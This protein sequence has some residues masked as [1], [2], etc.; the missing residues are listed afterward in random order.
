MRLIYLLA[1][2]TLCF[3]LCL[4]LEKARR[5]PNFLVVTGESVRPVLSTRFLLGDSTPVTLVYEYSK[6]QEARRDGYGNKILTLKLLKDLATLQDLESF[7]HLCREDRLLRLKLCHLQ[8]RV[9]FPRRG[10]C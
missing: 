9:G 1:S 8:C 3:H 6:G 10:R 2:F 7:G 5:V 4:P